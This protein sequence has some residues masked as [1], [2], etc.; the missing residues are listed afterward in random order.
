MTGDDIKASM[1]LSHRFLVAW[2][3]FSVYHQRVSMGQ[4][5]IILMCKKPTMSF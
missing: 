4:Y 5:A 1:K 3:E 2:H